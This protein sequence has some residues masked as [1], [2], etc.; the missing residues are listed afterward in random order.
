MLIGSD[1]NPRLSKEWGMIVARGRPYIRLVCGVIIALLGLLWIVQGLDLL[2]LEGG[3]NNDP[4][5]V[6]IGAITAFFGLVVAISGVRALTSR[7]S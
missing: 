3:M 2:G 4:T 1:G 7:R 6:V 5:W